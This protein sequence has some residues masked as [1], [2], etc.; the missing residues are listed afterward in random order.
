MGCHGGVLP[1]GGT[2]FI[3]SDYLK[4][5]LRLAAMSAAHAVF[6]F[7][8]DSVGVGEDG[9]THQP[10]EQL[11]G[12]RAIPG[13]QVIRPADANE[14]VAAWRVAVD[15]DGPTAL[16]LSRQS[17]PV[18]TDGSAVEPGGAVVRAADDARVV[19]LATGSEVAVCVEAAERLADEGLLASVVSLPSWDRFEAQPREYQ[20]AVLPPDV[21]VLSVEAAATF[22]WARW[23]DDSIGIDR[24]GASAPGGLVLDKLGIN[25]D[26]VVARARA[27]VAD[28]NPGGA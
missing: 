8:H 1:V 7:S 13:L 5:T 6:V 2:F 10:I 20:D 27:L 21:P 28:D 23:A 4:P 9:P 24:F 14:T 22:G 3:F 17:I 18:V 15:H 25:V 12:L 26:H 11:A 19:L 16:I